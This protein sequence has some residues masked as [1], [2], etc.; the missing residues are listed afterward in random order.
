MPTSTTAVIA[1]RQAAFVTPVIAALDTIAFRTGLLMKQAASRVEML[2]TTVVAHMSVA[3]AHFATQ[4]N[5]LKGKLQDTHYIGPYPPAS[6]FAK[7]LVAYALTTV[8]AA[9]DYSV[10]LAGAPPAE[11]REQTVGLAPRAAVDTVALTFSKW[12]SLVIKKWWAEPVL[13]AVCC[14]I[15]VMLP[16]AA[17]TDLPAY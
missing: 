7:M 16:M 4:S 12:T 6:S 14:S 3:T 8:I 2:A 5:L 10:L 15:S 9:V 1:F 13:P 17:A 11:E